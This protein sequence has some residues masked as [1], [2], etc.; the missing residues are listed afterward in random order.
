MANAPI[1]VLLV[2][3]GHPFPRDPFFAVFDDDPGITWT[4]VEH[5]AAD[6]LIHPD[7]C[8]EFDVLAF[9]D[10]PGIRF[11]RADPPMELTDPSP[12]LRSAWAALVESGKGLVF[13]HHAIAGWPTWPEY[14]RLLGGRF[15]YGPATLAGVDYPSSGY[16][17]DATHRV[18]VI[19]PDHPVCAGL[20]DGFSITDELY[21]F[22]VL[23]ADVVPLL[24]TDAT[25][26]D[27][28]FFSA[29]LAIRGERGSRRDWSHAPGSSLVGWV[30]H[31]G[32]SPVCY[33]QFGDG[34][35]TY[36]D[37]SYRRVIGNALR[38]AAGAAAHDWARARRRS[39]GHDG[40]TV[41][42]GARDGGCAA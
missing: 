24:R 17:F 9:Y 37:P 8:A 1:R 5:P 36:A 33:L 27:D 18:T 14:A 4:H 16:Q 30:K 29:D 28:H 26:T 41:D 12:E 11:T 34:P 20:G 7:R 21:L 38:W 42:G 40:W 25:L 32:N 15:H 13:L 31:A 3:K 19:D 39:L 22:P 23:E 6:Q 35:G 10:M 2:T